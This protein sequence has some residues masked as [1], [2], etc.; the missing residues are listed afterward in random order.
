MAAATP[1]MPTPASVRPRTDPAEAKRDSPSHTS[2]KTRR[3]GCTER[4]AAV[5]L[6]LIHYGHHT[7]GGRSNDD[8]R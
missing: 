6:T 2:R 1:S 3:L 8:I 7:A 5:I 4:V